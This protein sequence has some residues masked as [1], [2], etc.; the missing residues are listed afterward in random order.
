M[1]TPIFDIRDS[2]YNH[3]LKNNRMYCRVLYCKAT[4]GKI[5]IPVF[6]PRKSAPGR[7]FLRQ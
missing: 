5:G 2:I 1:H 6:K 7:S 3:Y 4:I